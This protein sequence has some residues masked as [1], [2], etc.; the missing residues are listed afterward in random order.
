MASTDDQIAALERAGRRHGWNVNRHTMG[1]YKLRFARSEGTIAVRFGAGGRIREVSVDVTG[2]RY[3]LSLPARAALEELLAR[4]LVAPE[5]VDDATKLALIERWTHP[6]LWPER[7]DRR[8]ALV[9]I[10]AGHLVEPPVVE[11]EVEL[12]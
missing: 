5:R 3:Q 11:H 6:G 10:L 12:P 4:P 2:L 8:E 1:Y 7:D 9:S